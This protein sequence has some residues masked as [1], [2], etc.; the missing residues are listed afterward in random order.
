MQKSHVCVLSL[1]A[2]GAIVY[3]YLRQT[4]RLR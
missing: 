1:V 4:G 3:V 2:G